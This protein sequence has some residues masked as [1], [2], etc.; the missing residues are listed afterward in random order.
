MKADSL[1]ILIKSLTRSEKGY[2]KRF[3][4]MHGS[5]MESNYLKLFDAIEGMETYEE[6]RV[7]KIL[8]GE[9]FIKQLSVTK[10][11]LFKLIVRA[12][13]IYH[14][15]NIPE[16][17]ILHQLAEEQ[18]LN[19][20]RL[21]LENG[22]LDKIGHFACKL[23][24]TQFL[25][26]IEHTKCRRLFIYNYTHGSDEEF[27]AWRD[28]FVSIHER[29]KHENEI[30]LLYKALDHVEHNF[31]KSSKMVAEVVKLP[32]MQQDPEHLSISTRIYFWQIWSD[33]YRNLL[34]MPNY[35]RCAEMP[36]SIIEASP[37][38]VQQE[39]VSHT[40]NAI[41][42]LCLVWLDQNNAAE[43]KK[44]LDKMAQL[45]L[46]KKTRL[47][48]LRTM[49]VAENTLTYLS[50]FGKPGSLKAFEADFKDKMDTIYANETIWRQGG[51]KFMLS[52]ALILDN[53]PSRALDY[54]NEVLKD[55]TY[56]DQLYYPYSWY[57]LLIAHFELGNHTLLPNLLKATNHAL[58]QHLATKPVDKAIL[59]HFKKLAMAAHKAEAMPT[60][61]S[62]GQLLADGMAQ[63]THIDQKAYFGITQ[64]VTRKLGTSSAPQ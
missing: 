61:S 47:E 16:L 10:N 25:P 9:P 49:W 40:L 53:E 62:L 58:K 38:A 45:D 4:Q 44:Y 54:L 57:W 34:D 39:Y 51:I 21:E 35:I 52:V 43:S 26:L 32:L 63:G 37:I 13:S 1:Y 14:R 30:M 36:I 6:A 59:K 28:K 41:F 60:L 22:Q 31:E 3:A 33:Y 20:R 55:K 8:E 17:Q 64:W 11:Y 19:S 24:K 23:H 15:E 2:F 12:L 48:R 42:G 5:E 50:Q 18:V 27:E 56:A 46:G 29:A 7:K